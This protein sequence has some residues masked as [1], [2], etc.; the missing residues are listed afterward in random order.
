M[1]TLYTYTYILF[2]KKRQNVI[3]IEIEIDNDI[4]TNIQ[5]LCVFI[6]FGSE[7]VFDYQLWHS[8]LL[9]HAPPA[10]YSTVSDARSQC[11]GAN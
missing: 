9:P 6:S 5:V 3:E 2:A 4:L 10:R 11:Q 7:Q 8:T 1:D